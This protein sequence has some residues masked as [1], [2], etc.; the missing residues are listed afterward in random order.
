MSDNN[1]NSNIEEVVHPQEMNSN[2]EEVVHPQ[3]VL[4]PND[5]MNMSG[6]E[7]DAYLNASEP[8]PDEVP[9][10]DD[11]KIGEESADDDNIDSDVTEP[12]EDNSTAAVEQKPDTVQ[13]FKVFNTEDEYNADINSAF[14]SRMKKH[15]AES[16]KYNRMSQMA[17]VYYPDAD[18]P[19]ATMMQD[20]EAQAAERE[21]IPVEEYRSRLD[22]KRD[23]ELY[24]TK[25][26]DE[27]KRR[28]WIQDKV[29][30]WQRDAE[31]LKIINPEFDLNEAMRNPEF[32]RMLRSGK[33]VAEAYVAVHK[34]KLPQ[35][36]ERKEIVQNGSGR[37]HGTGNRSEINPAS[38]SRKDFMEYIEKCRN[39]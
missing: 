19:V 37:N 15:N 8:T 26:R 11:V 18:D 9:G 16:D 33:S 22:D 34:P 36:A 2:T 39:A 21:S 17:K 13:P 10:D 27:E 28:Q 32:E 1:L 30:G 6:D 3:D 31:Q 24:R 25:M 23:A 7:F 5:I 20:L 4:T 38:L 29:N 35:T 14:R 12:V